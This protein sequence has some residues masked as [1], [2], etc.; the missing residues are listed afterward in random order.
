MG[1]QRRDVGASMEDTEHSDQVLSC[2]EEQIEEW[3]N[4]EVGRAVGTEFGGWEADN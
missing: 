2:T 4:D 3:M 1:T